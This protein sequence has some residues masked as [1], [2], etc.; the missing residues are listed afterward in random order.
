MADTN[1]GELG[2]NEALERA[3]QLPIPDAVYEVVRHN[4]W[5]GSDGYK[6]DLNELLVKG[7]AAEL[8]EWK[9]KSYKLRNEAYH[10]GDAGLRKD[11]SYPAARAQFEAANPG[12]GEVSYESAVSYGY[13]CAR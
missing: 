9:R 5:A 7:T 10:V 3:L 1:Y 13:F 2:R 6:I 12:F 8:T 4:E 11:G